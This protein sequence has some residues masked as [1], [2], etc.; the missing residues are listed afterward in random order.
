MNPGRPPLDSRVDSARLLAPALA[1]LAGVRPVFLTVGDSALPLA[2]SLARTFGVLRIYRTG[3]DS[4]GSGVRGALGHFR[5]RSNDGLLGFGA[6][7]AGDAAQNL[8]DHAEDAHHEPHLA[9]PK[10]KDRVVVLVDDGTTGD[11]VLRRNIEDLRNQAP[12]RLLLVS[13]V[14][15]EATASWLDSEVDR[16]VALHLPEEFG[17]PADWYAEESKPTEVPVQ[18]PFRNVWDAAAQL[19]PLLQPWRSLHPLVVALDD[20]AAA[21]AEVVAASLGTEGHI[22]HPEEPR[23]PRIRESLEG[24]R[25]RGSHSMLEWRDTRLSSLNERLAETL[26]GLTSG[27]DHTLPPVAGRTVMLVDDGVTS[28]AV[29]QAAIAELKDR[30]AAHILLVAP[31]LPLD[32]A[33]RLSSEVDAVIALYIPR[34]FGRPEDWYDAL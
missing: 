6:P 4:L 10:L 26:H 14:L 33:Q 3:L 27:L 31:V 11:Q 8:R 7:T 30:E 24:F 13:P 34:E 17:T 21:V 15:P 25:R 5:G 12:A 22:H 2:R 18:V 29:I 28:D 23:A 20:H 1:E 19:L 9:A 16:I 32:T